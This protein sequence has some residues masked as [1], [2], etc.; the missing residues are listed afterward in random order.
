M[1]PACD[2]CFLLETDRATN[3]CLPLSLSGFPSTSL[4]FFTFISRERGLSHPCD[5]RNGKRRSMCEPVLDRRKTIEK[6]KLIDCVSVL[7]SSLP[8]NLVAEG[9]PTGLIRSPRGRLPCFHALESGSIAAIRTALLAPRAVV[10]VVV[11]VASLLVRRPFQMT[12]EING[13]WR[14][15]FS[16][17]VSN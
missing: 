15:H 16:P 6:S 5:S 9:L 10:P 7:F 3:Q 4:P 1:G 17:A 14:T 13:Q 11:A 8:K 12:T 2:F